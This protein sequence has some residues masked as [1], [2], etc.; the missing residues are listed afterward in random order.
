MPRKS[1]GRTVSSRNRLPY[2]HD[3]D[4]SGPPLTYG[5]EDTAVGVPEVREFDFKGELN[6]GYKPR[7]LQVLKYKSGAG[8]WRIAIVE[9]RLGRVRLPESYYTK[10]A[11]DAA[12]EY[13]SDCVARGD[14]ILTI[15]GG[16]HLTF[17]LK[18]PL[19][20]PKRA[21]NE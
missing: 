8:G 17:R 19:Q 20:R 7:K 9:S 21:A 15:L 18:E 2:L 10:N 13:V 12:L 6:L 16:D 5:D 3:T 11:A 14:Y 4:S 1:Y